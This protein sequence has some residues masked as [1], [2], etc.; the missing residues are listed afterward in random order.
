MFNPLRDDQNQ[1]SHGHDQQCFHGF[2]EGYWC[3]WIV[4]GFLLF[5]KC[6]QNKINMI[7]MLLTMIWKAIATH[8]TTLYWANV[9]VDVQ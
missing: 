8:K 9:L 1:H 7:V 4:D 2:R 5:T 6:K 3:K